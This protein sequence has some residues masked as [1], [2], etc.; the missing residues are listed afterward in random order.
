[1]ALELAALVPQDPKLASISASISS[2][3]S[4]SKSIKT[5]NIDG[6]DVLAAKFNAFASTLGTIHSSGKNMDQ[7]SMLEVPVDL[8]AFLDGDVSN[9]ELY[10][11]KSMEDH[12]KLA[13]SISRRVSY[14]KGVRSGTNASIAALAAPTPPTGMDVIPA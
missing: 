7:S 8:L 12:E 10:L 4:V 11:A 14:L 2:L 6:P 13:E 3:E 5:D 9:P 1:M